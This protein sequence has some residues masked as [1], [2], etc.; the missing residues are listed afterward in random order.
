[1]AVNPAFRELVA[2]LLSGLGPVGLR[3]MFGG[4]GVFYGG[5]MFGLI[6]RDTLYFKVGEA[7]REDFLAAGAE[8]FLYRG[9]NGREIALGYYA[10]PEMLLEDPEEL[11]LWARKAIAVAIEAARR[12]PVARRRSEGAQ[13][14][15]KGSS[16]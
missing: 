8:P 12:E 13:R 4:A 9:K 7:N 10:L 5:T 14:A 6:A 2:E 11:V 15:R 1:M 16:R 3:S